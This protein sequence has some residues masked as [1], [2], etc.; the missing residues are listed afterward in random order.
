[1]PDRVRIL[2]RLN[3]E[4]NERSEGWI[5]A[6]ADDAE[7]VMPAGWPDEPIHHGHAGIEHV[8]ALWAENFDDYGWDEER[9]IETGDCV[10]G[11]YRHRGNIP[12]TD[13]RIDAEVGALF[14]FDG[15]KIIRVLTFGTW[16][17]ALAAAGLEPT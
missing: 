9:L 11:L 7:F 2:R 6:Y 12:G 10:V 17:E 5:A 16:A 4:F 14:Y 1:V 3:Q 15:D 8:V 13:R